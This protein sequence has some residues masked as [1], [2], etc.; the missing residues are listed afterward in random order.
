[1]QNSRA[2]FEGLLKL[3]PTLRPFVMTRA[4]YAGGRA[5]RG[6]LRQTRHHAEV[7]VIEELTEK[8][9]PENYLD[10]LRLKLQ[11]ILK[12]RSAAGHFSTLP[13]GR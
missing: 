1:M 6:N 2:T 3:E 4:S 9:S 11:Q 7:A 5:D 10:Y 13:D 12:P 8:P